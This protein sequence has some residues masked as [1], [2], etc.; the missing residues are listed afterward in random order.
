LQAA[1][2]LAAAAAR[3]ATRTGAREDLSHAYY[4]V[5]RR[6]ALRAGTLRWV[7]RQLVRPIEFD[8]TADRR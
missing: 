4:E 7:V 5:V 6:V 1:R 8:A 3:R 2:R